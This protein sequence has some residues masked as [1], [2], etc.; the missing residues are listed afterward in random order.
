MCYIIH[1]LSR[2]LFA[3]EKGPF[4]VFPLIMEVLKHTR[5]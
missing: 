1:L 2:K 4:C 5:K 3:R